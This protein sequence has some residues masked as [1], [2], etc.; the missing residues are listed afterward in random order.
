VLGSLEV[1]FAKLDSRL[2]P[3]E[4]QGRRRPSQ[5]DQMSAV[6]EFYK[7][8]STASRPNRKKVV[9]IVTIVIGA[10]ALYLLLPAL[11]VVFVAQPV[12]VEGTAMTP[13][14]NNGDKILV[15]KQLGTLERGD[16]VVFLFPQDTSKSFIK[17]IIGLPGDR[18]D[19]DVEGNVTIN[20]R[21]LKEDYIDPAHN[22]MARSRWNN[23]R[24]EWKEINPGFYFVMGDNR[25][26]SNDSRSWGP[27]PLNLIYG[28]YVFRYWSSGAP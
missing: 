1:V 22:N 16:I 5:E 26:A 7:P 6:D 15:S 19:V 25:D 2:R 21:N 20:S 8:P 28:K 23:V 14:L 10:C 9:L 13:T 12:R 4:S 24:S 27:V 17:R 18:I 11:T 3:E